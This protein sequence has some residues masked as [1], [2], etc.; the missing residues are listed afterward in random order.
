MSTGS[1]L[2][3]VLN[4]GVAA[5]EGEYVLVLDEDTLLTPGS[6]HAALARMREAD[7]ASVA[8]LE[9]RD[10]GDP[11][12]LEAATEMAARASSA[13]IESSPR[14]TSNAGLAL[15]C[16]REAFLRVRGLDER[17]TFAEHAGLDL[18]TRLSRAGFVVEWLAGPSVAAYHFGGSLCPARGTGSRPTTVA[19]PA[20]SSSPRTCRSS[21]T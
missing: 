8:Q 9:R 7:D 15:L 20:R 3:E 13:Y 18:L 4:C 12:S 6:V 1:R 16:R 17:P 11:G 21:G 10:C 2:T 5:A 19:R 14:A